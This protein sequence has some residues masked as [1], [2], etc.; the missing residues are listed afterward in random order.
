MWISH[1]RGCGCR[2]G[3]LAGLKVVVDRVV[4]WYLRCGYTGVGV[5]QETG[6]KKYKRPLY[7]GASITRLTK[8]SLNSRR[9]ACYVDYS[10]KA[11]YLSNMAFLEIFSGT[12]VGLSTV[13][14]H[15]MKTS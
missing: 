13:R 14:P 10:S 15:R 7:F 6:E 5:S 11:P 2:K 8:T 4:D 3:T 9:Q 1:E 12:P